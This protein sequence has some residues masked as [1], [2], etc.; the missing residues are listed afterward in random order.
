[1]TSGREIRQSWQESSR[2]QSE[3]PDLG[4]QQGVASSRSLRL[5]ALLSRLHDS[6]PFQDK[7]RLRSRKTPAIRHESEGGMGER[8]GS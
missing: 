1:M 7:S 6:T 2:K 4:P 8:S 5:R 3:R